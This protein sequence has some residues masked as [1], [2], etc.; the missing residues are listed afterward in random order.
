ML[1]TIPVL[2]DVESTF[3]SGQPLYFLW[4]EIKPWI[5][6]RLSG[7]NMIEV[8][9]ADDGIEVTGFGSIKQVGEYIRTVFRMDDDL[10]KI[11]KKIGTD[12]Y[13]R[14]MI[15]ENVGLRICQTD[16]WETIVCMI[17]SQNNNLKRIKQ[18]V[19]SIMKFGKLVHL[20]AGVRHR[21][22]SR[23]FPTPEQVAKADLKVCKLG[24][25]C[26]YLYKT[27]R[28]VA[29]GA[30]KGIEKK[31]TPKAREML[32]ELPGIGP[33]VA[34][35]ILLFSLGRL[36]VFPVDTN[37]QKQ[38]KLHYKLDT[39]KEIQEFA[40][41]KWGKYAGYAQQYIYFGAVAPKMREKAA[42]GVWAR[43]VYRMGFGRNSWTQ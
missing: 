8:R 6:W 38:M 2:L 26:D 11:Y 40:Q 29:D 43:Q 14:S 18:N 20:G 34:D 15:E 42:P 13:M 24:Y 3:L 27:A 1:F 16:L 19:Q 37:M 21:R 9:Q 31:S 36:E 39:I 17:C 35:T 33:K 12:P 7:E 28:L 4:H 32:M 41:K 25:R 5:W 10:I 22:H 23:E 30:L